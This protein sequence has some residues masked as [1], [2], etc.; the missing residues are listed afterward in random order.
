MRRMGP[1]PG[2]ILRADPLHPTVW[3]GS[4]SFWHSSHRGGCGRH[5]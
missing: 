4:K 1:P 5:R 3:D 2:P